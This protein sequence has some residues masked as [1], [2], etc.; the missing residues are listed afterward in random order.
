MLM[1]WKGEKKTK[2]EGRWLKEKRD[3]I[4]RVD[5]WGERRKW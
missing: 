4:K 1:K 3:G 2:E 5:R